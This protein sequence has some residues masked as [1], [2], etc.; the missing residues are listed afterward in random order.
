MRRGAVI[1]EEYELSEGVTSESGFTPIAENEARQI[2]TEE[3][4]KLKQEIFGD[5][6][7]THF[8]SLLDKQMPTLR[9]EMKMQIQKI[10]NIHLLQNFQEVIDSSN[11]ILL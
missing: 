3:L 5:E 8:H 1:N 4:K 10:P 11:Q 7:S 2:V 9:V 6:F